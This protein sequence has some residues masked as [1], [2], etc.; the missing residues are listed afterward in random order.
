MPQIKNEEANLWTRLNLWIW[1][2][3]EASKWIIVYSMID[4]L[5]PQ[6]MSDLCINLITD[7]SYNTCNFLSI[8][9]SMINSAVSSPIL[10][11]L[12]QTVRCF[13]NLSNP[14]G[15]KLIHFEPHHEKTC[16]AICE[17]KDADQPV[18]PRSLIRTFVA[19]FLDSIISLVSVSELSSL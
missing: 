7:A 2:Q 15:S 3:E 16:F 8:N 17:Q 1:I 5:Y 9:Q 4:T 11:L 18:H 13:G 19:C 6:C 14:P 10:L 12:S